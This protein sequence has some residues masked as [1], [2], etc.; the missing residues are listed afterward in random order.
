VILIERAALRRWLAEHSDA[1]A[2]P[3]IVTVRGYGYRLDTP[4]T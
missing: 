4:S 1:D 3:Q 2:V